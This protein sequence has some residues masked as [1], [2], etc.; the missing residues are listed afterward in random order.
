VKNTLIIFLTIM[1]SQ[2][3]MAHGECPFPFKLPNGAKIAGIADPLAPMQAA[4]SSLGTDSCAKAVRDKI[5]YKYTSITEQLD[6]TKRET[7]ILKAY[8]EIMNAI[9]SD[10]RDCQ[11]EAVSQSAIYGLARGAANVGLS[12]IDPTH[13]ALATSL[14]NVASQIM[15]DH[16]SK[17]DYEK[18]KNE[19]N[20]ITTNEDAACNSWQFSNGAICAEVNIEVARNQAKENLDLA[21]SQ[22]NQMS[23]RQLDTSL[24]ASL[25]ELSNIVANL[26]PKGQSADALEAAVKNFKRLKEL[27]SRNLSGLDALATDNKS[28]SLRSLIVKAEDYFNQTKDEYSVRAEVM[29][30]FLKTIDMDLNDSSTQAKDGNGKRND[31]LRRFSDNLETINQDLGIIKNGELSRYLR[32]YLQDVAKKGDKGAESIVAT[33]REI[34]E[35][36]MIDQQ[37]QAADQAL[38]QLQI[39]S[40]HEMPLERR[41]LLTNIYMNEDEGLRGKTMDFV[42]NLHSEY[43]NAKIPTEDRCQG[44]IRLYS[45][46]AYLKN[47]FFLGNPNTETDLFLFKMGE[48]NDSINSLKSSPEYNR[49]C[50]EF[51]AELGSPLDGLSPE[52]RLEDST[53][54]VSKLAAQSYESSKTAEKCAREFRTK[55]CPNIKPAG[56]NKNLDALVASK[57]FKD[58]GCDPRSA[59]AMMANGFSSP[60][61]NG[62]DT[63]NPPPPTN[64]GAPFGND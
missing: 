47:E 34:E 38:Q 46:C 32:D 14:V 60:P 2:T 9:P 1:L 5:N 43:K 19:I 59:K 61:T 36:E 23:N 3:K 20:K 55:N 26:K 27:V 31:G 24:S 53:Y 15:F 7:D 18:T 54:K 16:F 35:K 17:T 12:I 50:G 62:S 57:A 10:F 22:A 28:I 11:S 29:S 45:S 37:I 6:K 41:R 40:Y 64:E 4:M 42:K 49:F 56:Q 30:R 63:T 48:N 39:G 25:R 58:L 52:C 21:C 51:S 8:I 13:G 33:I 44:L